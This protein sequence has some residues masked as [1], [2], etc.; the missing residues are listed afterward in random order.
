MITLS[1]T[2]VLTFALFVPLALSAPA[3]ADGNV[4]CDAG[5]KE[6]W[7]SIKNLKKRVWIEGWQ[8]IKT[9]V[10]SDCYEVYARTESGQVIEAFFH[11][12]TLEKLVVFRRGK[13][14]YR[15]EGFDG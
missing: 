10:S 12:V 4:T 9:E 3:F 5:P 11:P 1:R 8:L 2:L 15:A 6:S 14:I 13:E 7:M